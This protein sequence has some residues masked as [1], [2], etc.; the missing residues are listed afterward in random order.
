[1]H[2]PESSIFWNGSIDLLMHWNFDE[3][4]VTLLDLAGGSA[5]EIV[6][7]GIVGTGLIRL[8]QQRGCVLITSDERTLAPL[9]WEQ[10]VHCELLRNLV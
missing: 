3:R 1:M 5:A 9:A 10:G 8:A 6:R 7:A 4:L 2:G